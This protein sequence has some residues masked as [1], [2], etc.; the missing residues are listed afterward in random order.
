M[1]F[2]FKCHFE[3]RPSSIYTEVKDQGSDH[4]SSITGRFYPV[5]YI[6]AVSRSA[7]ITWTEVG[8]EAAVL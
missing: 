2:Y 3:G 1:Y 8:Q 7:L 6:V 4:I 5:V